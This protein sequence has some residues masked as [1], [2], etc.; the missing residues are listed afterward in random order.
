MKKITY[1]L[2]IIFI[3]IFCIIN[4]FS[5]KVQADLGPK[6]SITIKIKN[7]NSDNYIIDLF[8]DSKSNEIY[9]DENK[10]ASATSSEFKTA[11]RKNITKEQADKLLYSLNYDGWVSA[12]TRDSFL[13]GDCM[14]NSSHEHY[15]RYFGVPE[16]Y[17]ILIINNDTG[18]IKLSKKIERR[19]F[20]SVVTI[21]ARTMK[22]NQNY[23]FNF[24]E[25]IE[26]IIITCVIEVFVAL[27]MN[28]KHT[29]QIILVNLLTQIGIQSLR[30][31]NFSNYLLSFIIAELLVF[32]IEYLIYKKL[33]KDIEQKKIIIYTI[34]AN[35]TTAMLTFYYNTEIFVIL[36]I[37][38]IIL[39]ILYFIIIGIKNKKNKNKIIQKQ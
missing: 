12:S 9:R 28:I 37:L 18:E 31:L 39:Y 6:P 15:F 26:S 29:K 21:D 5:N 23:T 16:T 19:D 11:K 13:W 33:F 30:L 3:L 32:F 38:S 4:I 1:K 2:L 20:N 14:G 10:Y 22:V 36:I 27:I 34:I 8:V 24:S 35:L 25:I 17:K 7:I